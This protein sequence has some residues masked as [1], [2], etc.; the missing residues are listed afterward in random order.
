MTLSVF[1]NISG[2]INLFDG[3]SF[4]FVLDYSLNLTQL[5]QVKTGGK[6]VGWFLPKDNVTLMLSQLGQ[7]NLVEAY[8]N[9]LVR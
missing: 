8:I 5:I 9:K 3:L 7:L 1:T 4:K 2:P 6:K